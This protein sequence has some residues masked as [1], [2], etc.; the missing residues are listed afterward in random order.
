M[1]SFLPQD[2]N[3][4]IYLICSDSITQLLFIANLLYDNVAVTQ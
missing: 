2:D 1:Q 3:R 4:G